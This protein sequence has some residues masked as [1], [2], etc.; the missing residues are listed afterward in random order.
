MKIR[1]FLL[2][3]LLFFSV[4]CI[5]KGSIQLRHDGIILATFERGSIEYDASDDVYIVEI[6]NGNELQQKRL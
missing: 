6:G 2:C 3:L 1:I 5:R 4:G